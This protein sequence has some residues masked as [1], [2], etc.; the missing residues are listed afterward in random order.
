MCFIGNGFCDEP[1]T[2]SEEAYWFCVRV[3][4]IETSTIRMSRPDFCCSAEEKKNKDKM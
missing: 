4:D 2:R 1:S 3:C